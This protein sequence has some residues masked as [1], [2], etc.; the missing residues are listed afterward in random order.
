MRVAIATQRPVQTAT[1]PLK[2]R[3]SDLNKQMEDSANY[4]K[5][6]AALK[7]LRSAAKD[8]PMVLLNL[9][10]CAEEDGRFSEAAELLAAYL[11]SAPKAID[12]P[13][14]KDD[15]QR[16]ESLQALDGPTGERIRAE[17]AE[18]A[19]LLRSGAFARA[20]AAYVRAEEAR[21]DYPETQ[22]RL[23]SLHQALG[24]TAEATTRY[25]Q[26]LKLQSDPARQ[27]AVKEELDAMKTRQ[28]SYDERTAAGEKMFADL[29][30]RAYI[31]GETMDYAFTQRQVA[32]LST[33]LQ[34]AV[35]LVPLAPRANTLLG[36]TYLV[37]NNYEA[38]KRSFL[39]V[40][41][42]GGP[43][44]FMA[45]YKLKSPGE[46]RGLAKVEI[47]ETALTLIPTAIWD[48]QG[49]RYVATPEAQAI[50]A[51]YGAGEITTAPTKSTTRLLFANVTTV[52]TKNNTVYVEAGKIELTI[53]PRYIV[54]FV[55]AEG[56]MA[57]RHANTYTKVF[58]D[59]SPVK[60]VKLGPEN[61][62]GG[63]KFSMVMSIAA[64]GYMLYAMVASYAMS[65]VQRI[66]A[67]TAAL[68]NATATLQTSIIR[69]REML[70]GSQFRLIPTE[71]PEP[72]FRAELLQ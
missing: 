59:F 18:A 35:S 16:L 61:M 55:P 32:Q 23:A 12:A 15:Q 72:K 37:G 47:T 54:S 17:Y 2:D 24:N 6:C 29:L 45:E 8:E 44:A 52:E 27:A 36:H 63:E 58:R 70:Q 26:Y 5:V 3:I 38:A 31:R 69:Q 71:A 68:Q 41:D 22:W 10:K 9:A 21:P 25:E 64:A 34:E 20:A 40:R 39:A 65:A 46:Q 14:V 1:G 43:V 11:K 66:Q 7:E 48:K 67:I 49:K 50:V 13:D 51:N 33:V 4:D 60:Q 62:T 30:N 28:A 57:R 53:M 19:K 56:K 42:K